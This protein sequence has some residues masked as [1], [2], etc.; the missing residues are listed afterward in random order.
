MIVV[1]GTIANG[2]GHFRQRMLKYPEAFRQVTGE[3]LFTGT[4]NIQTGRH[5]A[6]NEH[7]RLK[8]TLIGEPEQ[9]LVFEICRINRV[10]A[11][12]I[13]PLHLATGTGAHGDSVIEIAC[14]QEL[15]P[16]L[17]ASGVDIEVEL[18]RESA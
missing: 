13:R 7:F 5:I 6:L 17:S 14:A 8:G 18:F 1:S 16:S 3:N 10:W 11:Y 4:L 12:R 2:V 9:D 15:R